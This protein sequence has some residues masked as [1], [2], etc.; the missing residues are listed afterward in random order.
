MRSKIMTLLVMCFWVVFLVSCSQY[1]APECDNK[2]VLDL[3]KKTFL[4]AIKNN[5]VIEQECARELMLQG[6]VSFVR[7]PSIEEVRQALNSGEGQKEE[8]L[9]QFAKCFDL[10]SSKLQ[11]VELYA[12]R[13]EERSDKIQKAVCKAN[14]K[15]EGKDF[16][17]LKYTAQFTKDNQILVETLWEQ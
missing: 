3:A 17:T 1:G 2:Q 16:G 4:N 11:K 9:N 6:K 8:W 7:V 12:I 13:V 5:Q 10:Y 14:L 15:V